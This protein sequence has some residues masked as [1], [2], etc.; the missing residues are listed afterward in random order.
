MRTKSASVSAAQLNPDRQ[1]SLQFRQQVRGLG[2]MKRPRGDEQDMVGFHRPMFGRNRRALDQRQ[3]VALHSLAADI[4][5][6]RLGPRADLVDLV[7]KDDPVLLHRLDG[8]GLHRLVVQELVGFLTHQDIV[9]L[10]DRQPLA[11]RPPAEGLA[12][13]IAQVHAAAA[14]R[15]SGDLH[16]RKGGARVG[17]L[18]LDDRVVQFA[19]TQL[20]AEQIARP[21][22]GIRP[23]DCIEHPLLGIRLG[24]RA[25]ILAH[26]F[27]GHGDGGIGQVADDLLDIAAD[28]TN[29]GELGRLDLQE[30][31]AGELREPAADL[32]LADAGRADH[33][34]VLRK[35]LLAQGRV[36]LLAP[37]AVAQRH[38]HRAL[39]RRLANDE[40]VEFRDDLAGGQV[41]HLLIFSTVRLPF[42]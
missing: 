28:I 7:E 15:H 2:D 42:V 24:A 5:A 34:D 40:P 35:H 39:G 16:H 14:R 32:G 8:G 31:R 38:R 33:Q 41:G 3:Q 25:H 11:L 36:Q 27:A 19:R 9:A 18:D 26:V 6:A 10:G 12:K 29:L 23:C 21:G 17:H 20:L 22:A 1:P 37:P 30:G 4:G 13:E